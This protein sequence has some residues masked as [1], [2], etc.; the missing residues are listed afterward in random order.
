MKIIEKYKRDVESWLSVL[1]SVGY[2][3]STEN[4]EEFCY[5][6]EYDYGV[7]LCGKD[8][9]NTDLYRKLC[10]LFEDTDNLE[11]MD[12]S[13]I[14]QE[15]NLRWDVDKFTIPGNHFALWPSRVT[16]TGVDLVT[17]W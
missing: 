15:K 14:Q 2:E 17:C 6:P 8:F 1:K 11:D 3:F 16:K 12:L 13:K 10:E 5:D 7:S 4:F 9:D